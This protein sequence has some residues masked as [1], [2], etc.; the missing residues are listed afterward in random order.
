MPYLRENRPHSSSPGDPCQGQDLVRAQHR[1]LYVLSSAHNRNATDPSRRW[2]G[3]GP[4][5]DAEGAEETRVLERSYVPQGS[6]FMV[7]VNGRSKNAQSSPSGYRH[8]SGK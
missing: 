4:A 2:V 5:F 1:E 7:A 6:S 3:R 8:S